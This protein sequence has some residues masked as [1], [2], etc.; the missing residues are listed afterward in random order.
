[1]RR[2]LVLGAALSAAAAG[3]A[4]AQ[5][6]GE[7]LPTPDQP[8]TRQGTRGANFLEIGLGARANA[9]AGATVATVTGPLAWYWNPAGAAAAEGFGI[10]VTRQALYED[11]NI[12]H[13]FAGIVMPALGGVLGA[14]WNM[15][16]SGEIE[17]SLVGAPYGDG[18]LG[19]TYRWSSQAIGVGYARRLT[20]RL[21]IGGGLKFVSEG[22]TDASTN[23]VSFD[24]GT[25][26][27]TGLYGL[28][29]G[30]TLANVGPAARASG[31]AVRRELATD[32]AFNQLT[33]VRFD[34]QETDQPTLFRFS[35]GSELVG[36]PSALFGAAGGPHHLVGELAFMDAIDTDLQFAAGLEYGFNNLAFVRLGKRFFNDSRATEG[37]RYGFSGGLGL[38]LPVGSRAV[39]FDYA[40]MALGELQNIQVFS[41]EF[42]R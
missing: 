21:D 23:W 20:D 10:A 26:F 13:G 2:T 18:A 14:Q 25:Q 19:N 17:R 24:L 34:V 11:L 31:N 33:A 5:F 39:R 36:S 29:I 28:T 9:M 38:R 3:V 37:A 35:V 15:L 7:I 8:P 16:N 22:I 1:M 27:R 6:P 32:R 30:A 41:F 4:A 12:A 40:Y 42:G